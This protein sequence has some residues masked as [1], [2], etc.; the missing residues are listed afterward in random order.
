MYHRRANSSLTWGWMSAREQV[1][2]VQ[3]LILG[4]ACESA[5][6]WVERDRRP[7]LVIWRRCWSAGDHVPMALGDRDDGRWCSRSVGARTGCD[8]GI[9]CQSL[10]ASSA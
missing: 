6:R 2:V 5:F 8:S 3:L 9:C 10:L 7:R 1:E 4:S